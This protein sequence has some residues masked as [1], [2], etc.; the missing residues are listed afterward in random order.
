MNVEVVNV[1]EGVW[2]IRVKGKPVLEM[3]NKDAAE[4]A[5][6]LI[7]QKQLKDFWKKV[8]R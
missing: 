4:D 3:V 7:R 8:G 6:Y 2:Q 1:R 5:A